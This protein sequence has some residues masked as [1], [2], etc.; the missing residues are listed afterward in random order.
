M[1]RKATYQGERA[2]IEQETRRLMQKGS[3]GF[4][5]GADQPVPDDSQLERLDCQ[6]AVL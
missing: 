1:V 5:L 3:R 2:A 4:D 6:A